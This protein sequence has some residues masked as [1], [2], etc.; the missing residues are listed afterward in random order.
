MCST[1]ALFWKIN[2][3]PGIELWQKM[4]PGTSNP[5]NKPT[6]VYE[7]DDA[8]AVD[9]DLSLS[10]VDDEENIPLG[11][12]MVRDLSRPIDAD[13]G[14]VA[15]GNDDVGYKGYIKAYIHQDK[16]KRDP[17]TR[18]II[19]FDNP[20]TRGTITPATAAIIADLPN[21]E[22]DIA[23]RNGRGE[24]HRVRRRNAVNMRDII[25]QEDNR[26]NEPGLILIDY[27]GSI[28]H[29]SDDDGNFSE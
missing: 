17:V 19:G 13:G 16:F 12:I 22:A 7:G 6:L 20:W 2:Q 4:A 18:K 25:R 9:A 1:D 10:N 8:V 14:F 27:D 23:A 5:Q 15:Q 28:F 24:R 11:T 26:R 3:G 21:L 29:I